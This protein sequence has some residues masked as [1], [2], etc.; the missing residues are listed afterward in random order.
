M[1]NYLESGDMTEVQADKIQSEF[2][3]YYL[4]HHAVM[5][6]DSTTTKLRVVF[7]GSAKTTSGLSLNDVQHVGPSWVQHGMICFQL[8]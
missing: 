5:K 2:P 8:C 3:T 4:P 1:I 7:D 6:P